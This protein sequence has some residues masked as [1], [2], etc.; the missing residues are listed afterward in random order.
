MPQPNELAGEQAEPMQAPADPPICLFRLRGEPDRR[1]EVVNVPL[2][3]KELVEN[4]STPPG[5][6]PSACRVAGW[7]KFR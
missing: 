7:P 3:V 2:V 6:S 1:G 4:S 5:A